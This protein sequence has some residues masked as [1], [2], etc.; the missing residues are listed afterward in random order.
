MWRSDA[1]S[2][3][4]WPTS[5]W[6]SLTTGAS[7][8]VSCSSTIAS[9][10]SAPSSSTPS[11]DDVADARE[12]RDH[13]R[14]VV[15]R[16]DRDADLVAGEDRDVVDRVDVGRVGHRDEQRAVADERDRQRLV[17]LGDLAREEVRRRHVDVEDG[18]VD[19][20]EPVALGER[21]GDPV[22]ADLPAREQDLLGR[23]AGL[24]RRPAI[25]SSTCSRERQA[26][27]DDDVGRASRATRSRARRRAA[28][29]WARRRLRVGGSRPAAASAPAGVPRAQPSATP[30][31]RRAPSR[32]AGARRP[33]QR[34][35]L[36]APWATRIS[37]P[38]TVGR[39]S[40]RA[41]ATSGVGVGG[42]DEVDDART[43]TK[44]IGIQGQRPE[45][46]VRGSYV[47][48]CR[49]WS[50]SRA[51]PP[52]RGRVD[53]RHAD[54]RRELAR[55]L[56]RRLQTA[57]SAPASRSAQ[58]AAR[59]VPPGPEHD[60]LERPPGRAPSAAISPGASVLAASIRA[61][62]ART[63]ACWR[64]RSRARRRVAL[65][66]SASAAVLVRHGHVGADEAGGRAAPGP[67]RR[68][69]RA[70]PAAAGSVQPAQAERARTRR[71][72]SPASGCGAPA[73]RARRA[74]RRGAVRRRSRAPR[75]RA[76]AV[77]RRAP[78]CRRRRR[79][80]TARWSS[81]TRACR[82]CTG[83]ST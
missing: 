21:D 46:V 17:A 53:R 74:G 71:G 11:R 23:R 15:A 41:A 32:R 67:S 33:V 36:S 19:E 69:A 54:V 10:S 75:R 26:E 16:R 48:P 40:S 73:S 63:S 70:A 57:T 56:G 37:S 83:L 47:R 65:S 72:A 50:R 22:G 9:A 12:A 64:R 14:D 29:R 7:S 42:V 35:K 39:P 51:D 3:T 59:A 6:T 8:A 79:P 66:A 2:S 55:A 78:R 43:A 30:P 49:P 31:V 5:W 25:A 60:A 38:S 20:V 52:R 18:E 62:G 28:R 13:R 4:A 1:P 61:V 34:S 68:R 58:T 24:A 82:R 80:G 76:A 45:R 44:Q 81:R 77:A 27:L